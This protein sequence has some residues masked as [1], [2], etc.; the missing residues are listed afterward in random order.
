LLDGTHV[1]CSV[2]AD[3]VRPSERR[4]NQGALELSVEYHPHSFG[5][6]SG[7]T[8][9][10]SKSRNDEDV[11]QQLLEDLLL[12]HLVDLRC[13]CLVRGELAW[14]LSIDVLV[15][16]CG[17]GCSSG[18]A[19]PG[20]LLDACSLTVVAALRNTWLP[21]VAILA[22]EGD[23]Q[24][25]DTRTRNSSLG[26]GRQ[27]ETDSS[28]DAPAAELVVEGDMAKARRVFDLTTNKK[29]IGTESEGNDARAAE[30]TEP[31]QQQ[32]QQQQDAIHLVTVTIL[33]CYATSPSAH[34][35]PT[36][37]YVCLLDA[38]CDEVACSHCQIHVAVRTA[39]LLPSNVDPHPAAAPAPT[40][41]MASVCALQTS[42]GGSVHLSL[43]SEASQL[44]VTAATTRQ[45][46]VEVTDLSVL[47]G[48]ISTGGGGGGGGRSEPRNE[49]MLLQELYALQ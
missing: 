39:P 24:D 42:G 32:Q 6:G 33:K 7:G 47:A 23:D 22:K 9:S 48:A 34:E 35:P 11:L 44:A 49:T 27:R 17:A 2:K 28:N 18:V 30:Q 20:A 5:G 26:R 38:S 10:R 31:Q 43:I 4:P 36:V 41:R 40:K 46:H 37:R 45:R 1:L 25:E 12:P 3:I 21:S 15:L 13:L 8:S 14:R 29:M 19:G 16:S